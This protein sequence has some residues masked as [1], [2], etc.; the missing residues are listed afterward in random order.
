MCR[1]LARFLGSLSTISILPFS[2]LKWYEED[3]K[4]MKAERQAT[5]KL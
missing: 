5:P 2:I 4:R 3:P 1:N